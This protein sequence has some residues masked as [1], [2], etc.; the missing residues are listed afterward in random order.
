MPTAAQD[1][2]NIFHDH[3]LDFLSSPDRA[4]SCHVHV[5]QSHTIPRQNNIID[6]RC[7]PGGAVLNSTAC[8]FSPHC[9]TQRAL[10][11]I[12]GS[13]VPPPDP[14]TNIDISSDLHLELPFKSNSSPPSFTFLH[15]FSTKS[16]SS[17]PYPLEVRSSKN[18]QNAIESSSSLLGVQCLA[19]E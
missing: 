12:Q 14:T 8:F 19:V 5:L 17:F 1:H 2:S 13:K 9:L 15:N 4:L 10:L 11:M 16:C 6:C 7:H 3:A 18:F